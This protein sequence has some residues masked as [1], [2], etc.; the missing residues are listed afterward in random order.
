M[1]FR[2]RTPRRHNPLES[3]PLA[4]TIQRPERHGAVPRRERAAHAQDLGAAAGPQQPQRCPH[5]Q[6]VVH[7]EGVH[8]GGRRRRRAAGRG[9]RRAQLDRKEEQPTRARRRVAPQRALDGVHS[10]VLTLPR[11]RG[12]GAVPDVAVREAAAGVQPGGGDV[13][14]H[15]RAV[16]CGAFSLP[17]HPP[18]RAG[19]RRIRV[20]P[21]ERVAPLSQPY[22]NCTLQYV[23][24][25]FNMRLK[26]ST[27]RHPSPPKS[28]CTDTGVDVHLHVE[29]P[30]V[31]TCVLAVMLLPG[32]CTRDPIPRA[33]RAVNPAV[34]TLD[35]TD[36]FTYARPRVSTAPDQDSVFD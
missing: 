10:I 28:S 33:H 17:A 31:L 25:I 27:E 35:A 18:V 24:R 30:Q 9:P 1:V 19:L 5:L 36:A 16:A 7:G 22:N 12:R 3:H 4:A 34:E 20:Q 23:F 21:V 13:P 11:R 32:T 2:V 14:P 8:L 6:P 29:R 26:G 15:A